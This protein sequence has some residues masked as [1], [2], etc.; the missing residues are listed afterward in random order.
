ME[1][2]VSV[3]MGVQRG[4]EYIEFAIEAP[5]DVPPGEDFRPYARVRQSQCEAHLKET[6]AAYTEANPKF[7]PHPAS[8]VK[9]EGGGAART[10]IIPCETLDIKVLKGQTYWYIQGGPYKYGVPLYL[11]ALKP[12]SERPWG[13]TLPRQQ[14]GFTPGK[15]KAEIE[16]KAD[17]KPRR[18]LKIFKAE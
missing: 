18:V 10:E 13:E 7:A 2:R 16:L 1:F 11:D 3:K 17:G 8:T 12:D 6:I 4:A 15:W 5:F 9:V 14:K